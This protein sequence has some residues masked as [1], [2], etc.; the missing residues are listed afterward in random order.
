[1]G[2]PFTGIS[3]SKFLINIIIIHSNVLSAVTQKGKFIVW[4]LA[5]FIC[6]F[7]DIQYGDRDWLMAVATC[8]G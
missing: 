7:K 5:G 2:K 4:S 3:M 8:S 1:M 6:T